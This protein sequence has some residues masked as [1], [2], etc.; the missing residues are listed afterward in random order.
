MI[1]RK[2]RTGR[3]GSTMKEAASAAGRQSVTRPVI[4][5]FV[6]MACVR[7]PAEA[8]EYSTVVEERS[9][10]QSTGVMVSNGVITP[11]DQEMR[12]FYIRNNDGVIEVRL[13]DDAVVRLQTRVQRGGFEKRKG[14]FQVGQQKF[15]YDLP[16]DLYVKRPFKDWK[17]ARRA[18]DNPDQPILCGK[19]YVTPLEDHLP[20]EDELWIAGRLVG[21]EGRYAGIT[22]GDRPF[23][24]AT[25]GHDGQER[26]IVRLSLSRKTFHR[27]PPERKRPH[28]LRAHSTSMSITGR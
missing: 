18:L 3:K 27:R 20:T 16:R 24:M 1:R 19:I 10:S 12:N 21:K 17:S 15:S 11:L 25:Q 28:G 6:A 26:T 9:Y 7:V 23:K 5:C 13:T 14:E 4:L 8:R 2:K 22:V